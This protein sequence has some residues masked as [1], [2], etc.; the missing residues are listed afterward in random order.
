MNIVRKFITLFLNKII[1][2]SR[3]LTR[4]LF[5]IKIIYNKKAHWDFTTLIFKRTLNDTIKPN[6]NVLEIG[7]GPHG[8][9][10]IYLAKRIKCNI[11]AC[12]INSEYV[13][14][15]INTAKVNGVNFKII[16]SDLLGNIE[17]KFD[18][19]F[20]NSIYIPREIGYKLNIDNIC[21][22]ETDWCGGE[23]GYESIER[24]FVTSS[25][26]LKTT[27][28]ILL[29]FNRVYLKEE[30]VISRC[31]NL[32]YSIESITKQPFNPSCVVAFKKSNS[33]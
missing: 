30:E 31:R 12:D 5:G 18:I 32:D 3:M 6:F 26:H 25:N 16:Q 1:R 22:Y 14:N 9:L 17:D 13:D 21:Q 20:W 7:T 10:S 11:I 33:T 19:I 4:V 27:G 23:T 29:G 15:A 24:L 2:K 28:K 8:I